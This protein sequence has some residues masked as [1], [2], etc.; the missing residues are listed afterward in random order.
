M[1]Q[2]VI[3]NAAAVSFDRDLTVAQT[4]SASRN[5]KTFRKGP[6]QGLLEVQMTVMTRATY[7][8][9]LGSIANGLQGPYDIRLLPEIVGADLIVGTNAA[10]RVRGANQSSTSINILVANI[11][12]L[13]S[14]PAGTIVRF[15]GV[16]GSYVV[17]ADAPVAS[18]TGNAT[19]RL[20]QPLISTPADN[21]VISTN[22]GITFSM[23]LLDRP[24]ASFGP[25]GL[26]SHSGPFVYAEVVG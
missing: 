16:N 22:S 2:L 5:L 13:T 26:V 18:G 6:I 9:I 4:I 10:I 12:G 7:Q 23:Y 24:R 19:I 17:T 15:A 14:I 21:A 20:D 3:D 1:S 11:T 8:P 25:T